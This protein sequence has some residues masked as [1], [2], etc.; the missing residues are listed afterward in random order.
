MAQIPRE[1]VEQVLQATDIVDLV[2]SY[3]QLKRAGST[4]KANCPFH[5]EKTPS[6]TVNPGMQ[7]YHCFGCGAGGDAISF[8]REYENLPFTEAVRKLAGRAGIVLKEEADDPFAEEK[9]KRRG[10]LLDLHREAA[11]Y[12]HEKL[13]RDPAAAHAREYLKS[14]GYGAEMAKRWLVG[15]M[16]ANEREFLEWVRS[17][18]FTGRELCASGMAKM[19]DE[20]NPRAGLWAGLF[21]DRLM[22]PVCNELGDVI[23]FSG[24]QLKEDKRSGKYVNSPETPVFKKSQVL[25]G[26]DRA[27]KPMLK[28]KAAVLCEGQLDAIACHE[29]GVEHAV[30]VQGT[31]FTREQARKLRRYTE[32][33][34][35]CFD[36][37]RAGLEKA[38]SAF[39]ELAAEGLTVRVV[40]LPAGDDPDVFLKRDGVEAFRELLDKAKD[41]FDFKLARARLLG[42][43]DTAAGKA[44]LLTDC[45]E[46]LSL[47][48]DGSAQEVQINVVATYLQTSSTVLRDE[49]RKLKANPRRR[50]REEK[51]EERGPVVAPTSVHRIVR[52]LCHLALR[53]SAAQGFLGEQSETLH[54]AAPWIEGVQLLEGVL[55]AAPDP[56]SPAA[57]NAYLAGVPEGDR[58][59]LTEGIDELS[60][61]VDGLR[62][63]EEALEILSGVALQRRDAAIKAEMGQP[64]LSRERMVELLEQAKEVTRLLRGMDKRFVFNDEIAPSTY[65]AKEPEWKK[66]WREKNG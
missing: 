48:S 10:R 14:R 45:A 17:K 34:L 29:A 20:R 33:V 23:A 31:A 9:R 60:D 54:E 37:D 62:E 26:L 4:F 65:K 35:I 3:I 58:K 36:G 22:F 24:R 44:G 55:G 27:K 7:R 6:F 25:F 11:K 59:A 46:T 40:E 57:V 8:V 30:G 63:A 28:E 2:G 32:Q 49:I 66:K 19:N 61:T 43:F 56:G 64:G 21:R 42:A 39:K 41:F 51:V 52:Y 12:F 15:W 13:M 47:I 5:T 1:S 50:V 16:P 18:K 53:S 38:E